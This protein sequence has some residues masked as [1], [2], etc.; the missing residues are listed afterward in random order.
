MV[1]PGESL[2]HGPTLVVHQPLHCHHMG[3]AQGS[4]RAEPDM[5]EVRKTGKAAAGLLGF[6]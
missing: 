3:R 1:P 6:W 4:P 5:G 2:A